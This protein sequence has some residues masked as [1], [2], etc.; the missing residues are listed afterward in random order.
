MTQHVKQIRPELVER[1]NIAR[2]HNI[3]VPFGE[4]AWLRLSG[5][6]GGSVDSLRSGCKAQFGFGCCCVAAHIVAVASLALN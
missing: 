2:K 3:D 4:D 6:L 1:W 5:F